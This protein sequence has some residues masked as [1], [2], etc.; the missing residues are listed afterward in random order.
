MINLGFIPK[1]KRGRTVNLGNCL[2]KFQNYRCFDIFLEILH[3]MKMNLGQES[4]KR[5]FYPSRAKI[6]TIYHD[7]PEKMTVFL[8]L[9]LFFHPSLPKI[10]L[11]HLHEIYI[12]EISN[13]RAIRWKGFTM[14]SL[15]L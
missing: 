1:F 10:W 7:I 15:G 6:G 9:T 4:V 5:G 14:L 8:V 3:K 13:N 12:F 2:K 11:S